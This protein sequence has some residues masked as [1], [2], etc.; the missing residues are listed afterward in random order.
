MRITVFVLIVILCVSLTCGA[1][2][3]FGLFGIIPDLLICFLISITLFD[4]SIAVLFMAP[5]AGLIIDILYSDAWGMI[6]IPYL[7]VATIMFF[8]AT[9][10][11]INGKIIMPVVFGFT[12]FLVKDILCMFLAFLFGNTS[13]MVSLF[14]RYSIPGAAITGVLT[15]AIYFLTRTLFQIQW[16]RKIKTD[17]FRNL[18]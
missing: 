17:D 15:P 13:D 10:F 3:N 6:A 11:K 1:F 2:S 7:I 5:A 14:L 16:L 8:F 9:K 4:K 18:K 12:L